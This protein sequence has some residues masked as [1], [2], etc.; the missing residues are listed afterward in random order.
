MYEEAYD[1]KLFNIKLAV[2]GE[3]VVP[4]C[5]AFTDICFNTCVFV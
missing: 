2:A 1:S 3:M 4:V 5:A